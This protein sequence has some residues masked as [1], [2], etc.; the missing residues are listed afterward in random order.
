MSTRLST[1]GAG[2]A[3]G[4]GEG[5][6]GARCGGD[7]GD[8]PLS[9]A[10]C[11]LEEVAGVGELVRD[12][13]KLYSTVSLKDGRRC[14]VEVEESFFSEERGSEAL[15]VEDN[16]LA[17]EGPAGAASS[18][19]D[20]SPVAGEEE[21]QGGGEKEGVLLS[22]RGGVGGWI[23]GSGASSMVAVGAAGGGG[24]TGTI[25]GVKRLLGG[26]LLSASPCSSASSPSSR[27]EL[28]VAWSK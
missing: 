8:D 16:G 23:V 26:S 14:E 13:M 20:T 7:G 15:R 4:P 27:E 2:A 19:G 5:G 28:K 10:G 11:G 1:A 12:S 18:A 24:G 6:E 22:T 9:A 25:S 21:G 17:L 3:E